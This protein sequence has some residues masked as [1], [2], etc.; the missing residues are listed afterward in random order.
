MGQSELQPGLSLRGNVNG[1]LLRGP[2][3][4]ILYVCLNKLAGPDRIRVVI[5]SIDPG[6]TRIQHGDRMQAATTA[7]IENSQAISILIAPR[8]QECDAS[9]SEPS[10]YRSSSG[11]SRASSFRIRSVYLQL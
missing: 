9:M 4:R 3:G 6:G 2:V 7:Y 1:S 10:P 5:E 11:K 8:T